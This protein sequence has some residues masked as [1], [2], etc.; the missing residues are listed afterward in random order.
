MNEAWLAASSLLVTV[1]IYAACRWLYGKYRAPWLSPILLAPIALCALLLLTATPYRVYF[2]DTRWLMWLLGPATIAFAYPIYE[3]RALIRR[4][5]LSLIA[6]V[7][8]GVVLGLISSVGMSRLFHL[9][10]E[11]AR[12]LLPRSVSTPF[13]VSASAVFGGKRELTVLFVLVT[14]V[15]GMLIGDYFLRWL[16]VASSMARGASFGAGA[17]AVG[18]AKA[19][20]LSQ[21]EGAIASLTMVFAGIAMVLLAPWLA[22]LI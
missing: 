8:T 12:S 18:T 11:V 21:E 3:Q 15:I 6:G 16:R 22:H 17:H 7:V 1:V 14:G 19:R 5:P 9:P 20:E 10:P 13:A 4:Y 2:Q